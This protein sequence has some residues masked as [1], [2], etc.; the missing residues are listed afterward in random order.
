MTVTIRRA[1]EADAS[2]LSRLATRLFEETFRPMNDPA[3]MGAY[4]SHAFSVEAERAALRDADCAVWIV[5]DATSS[6]MGYAMMR[7]GS[8]ASGVVAKRPAEL[9]RIYVDRGMHGL[10]VGD[11]LMRTCVEHA[12]SW[13]CDVLW[14][15]VWEHNPR[16]L[17]FY[18]KVG[19]RVVGRQ[20]FQLGS[21]LQQDF[22][23]ARPLD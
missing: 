16:A 1:T 3:D 17:A 5:E 9:Q 13:H 11:A 6:A 10:G 2:L 21:D 12:R 22:V 7:C 20:S 4:V 18:R 14:L 23:M 15:G 19:F 8:T